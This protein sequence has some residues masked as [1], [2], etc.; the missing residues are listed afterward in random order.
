M[1]WCIWKAIRYNHSITA[2]ILYHQVLHVFTGTP[3]PSPSPLFHISSRI[4]IFYILLSLRIEVSTYLLEASF[5]CLINAATQIYELAQWQNW[6]KTCLI[7]CGHNLWWHLPWK[8]PPVLKL[9]LD[10][11]PIQHLGVFSWWLLTLTLF[12]WGWSP[13]ANLVLVMTHDIEAA[14]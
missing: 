11:C 4:L 8:S 13:N 10:S 14:G 2:G 5:V 7:S 12:S 9:W 6:I 1:E 3:Y